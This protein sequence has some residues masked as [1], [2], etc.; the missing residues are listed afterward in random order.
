MYNIEIKILRKLQNPIVPYDTV[1][2]YVVPTIL[3]ILST[4]YQ[5]FLFLGTIL[6][7]SVDVSTTKFIF[8]SYFSRPISLENS[9]NLLIKGSE[10]SFFLCEGYHIIHFAT[11]LVK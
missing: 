2:K 9:R 7:A 11:Y 8:V 5:R 4:V 10:G 6:A 1:K 3:T